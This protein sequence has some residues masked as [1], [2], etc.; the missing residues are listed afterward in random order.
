[1]IVSVH[2]PAYLSWLGYFHKIALADVFVFLDDTQFEKNSFVN[3]NRIKT[4]QGPIWL[5]VP[6]KLG[7]HIDKKISEIE[8]ADK[9]WQRKHWQSIELNYKKSAYWQE[10]SAELKNFYEKDF[11]HIADLC[12]AQLQWFV[13]LLGLS[14]K[15]I[16]ASDLKLDNFKKQDLIL[17]ICRELKADIYVSG[18]QGKNYI[19]L[20][21]FQAN[22]VKV[23]F[24]DYHHPK[25]SQL[26]AGFEPFMGI[27]DLFLNEGPKSLEIILKNNLTKNLL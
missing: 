12:F 2:Q 24:Q 3:R 13:K 17:A 9:V 14:T 5:T 16:K 21:K 23:Y 22:G 8:I 18:Q 1:M 6:V 19:T 26:W 27:I 20:E 25:Y 15:I 7:G 10:Y 4:A 11:S